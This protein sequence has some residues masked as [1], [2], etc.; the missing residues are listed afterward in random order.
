MIQDI[1]NIIKKIGRRQW[2]YIAILSA[3]TFMG[4]GDAYSH[5]IEVSAPVHTEQLS[6]L[7]LLDNLSIYDLDQDQSDPLK[8]IFSSWLFAQRHVDFIHAR[9]Q[10]FQTAFNEQSEKAV[11]NQQTR[12]FPK[13]VPTN[14]EKVQLSNL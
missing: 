9:N 13:K 2:C 10:H 1:P 14:E 5:D 3:F 12:I 6:D 7:A 8:A 4:G 11:I